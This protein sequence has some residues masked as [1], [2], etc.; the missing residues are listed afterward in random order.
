M[1]KKMQ[2]FYKTR[3]YFGQNP[4]R[5]VSNL[6]L[7]DNCQTFYLHVFVFFVRILRIVAAAKFQSARGTSLFNG[8]LNSMHMGGEWHK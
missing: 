8:S 7:M 6:T 1:F 4:K 5:E 3:G 2:I